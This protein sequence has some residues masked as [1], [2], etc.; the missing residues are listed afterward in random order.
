M[1][2][3]TLYSADPGLRGVAVARWEA[4]RLE[5]VLY[6]QPPKLSGERGLKAAVQTVRAFTRAITPAGGARFAVEVMQPDTR[7]RRA[8]V[9][10]VLDVS[11]VAGGASCAFP[12]TEVI[13]VRA[14]DWTRG[15]PKDARALRI[16]RRLSDAERAVL[17]EQMRDRMEKGDIG[18][19][20]YDH[21]ADA[22]GIGLYTLGRLFAAPRE[23]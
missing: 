2:E 22:I 18:R 15:I 16:W 10:A 23:E 12:W 7:S 13:P 8:Q 20:K 19:G 6:V 9:I 4:G 21:C 11:A 17:P 14:G 5:Q 3:V 1:G